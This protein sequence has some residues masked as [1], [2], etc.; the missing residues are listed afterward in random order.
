MDLVKGIFTGDIDL[1]KKAFSDLMEAFNG[2]GEKFLNAIGDAF[3]GLINGIGEIFGFENLFA[4]VSEIFNNFITNIQEKFLSFWD[5]VGNFFNNAIDFVMGIPKMISDTITNA[6]SVI[7]EFL[8]ALP[9]KILNSVKSLFSPIMD[10]FSSIGIAIKQAINGIIDALPMPQFLKDKIK[11]D[12]PVKEEDVAKEISAETPDNVIDVMPKPKV[13]DGVIV[14]ENN[15][16]IVYKRFDFAKAAA[17]VQNITND[18]DF[19]AK[20]LGRGRG[21]I[22]KSY[23]EDLKPNV[24]I[25]KNVRANPKELGATDTSMAPVVITRGGDTVTNSNVAKT[26]F[27]NSPL[28]VNVDNYHDRMSVAT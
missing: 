23:S 1:I 22:V 11:F 14:D 25:T 3:K 24:D 21:F 12:I 15:E 5:S 7:G 8:S 28:N 17:K 18:G 16:P 10:F 13:K 27:N 20:S 4:T 19:E 26:D 6:V 2:I 9:G